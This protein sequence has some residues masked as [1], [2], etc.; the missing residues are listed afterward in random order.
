MPRLLK[1]SLA[2]FVLISILLSLAV[3]PQVFAAGSLAMLK[4]S[5][6]NLTGGLRVRKGFVAGQGLVMR[7]GCPLWVEF[8]EEGDVKRE[9]GG[10]DY[11]SAIVMAGDTYRFWKSAYDDV[12]SQYPVGEG[13]TPKAVVKNVKEYGHKENWPLKP[14]TYTVLVKTWPLSEGE[15]PILLEAPLDLNELEDLDKAYRCVLLSD[16]KVI[17][18]RSTVN[19]G[20]LTAFYTPKSGSTDFKESGGKTLGLDYL[21]GYNPDK[22]KLWGAFDCVPVKTTMSQYGTT[23][24]EDGFYVL[25]YWVW[26]CPC[27]W[28]DIA[29]S[30]I[31]WTELRYHN[32]NP[33]SQ[34]GCGLYYAG[35]NTSESCLGGITPH[36][37]FN[38][39]IDMAMLTGMARVKNPDNGEIPIVEA[40]SATENPTTYSYRSTEFV[41]PQP[42]GTPES[43]L[44]DVNLFDAF[45]F[46]ADGEEDIAEVKRYKHPDN[47]NSIVKQEIQIWFG[48]KTGD[49]GQIRKPDLTRL[50]DHTPDLDHQGLLKQIS[51]KDLEATDIFVYRLSNNQLVC[52]RRGIKRSEGEHGGYQDGGVDLAGQKLYFR[53]PMRG[54]ANN[55]QLSGGRYFFGNNY[56]DWKEAQYAYDMAEG[57]LLSVKADHLRVGEPVKVILINRVTGYMGSGTATVGA[58]IGDAL[59]GENIGDLGKNSS[60]NLLSF[61]CE[62]IVMEPPNIRVRAE[63]SWKSEGY[64]PEEK[65]SLVGFEGAGLTSD[66]HI[67]VTV[68]WLDRDG[69]PLPDDLPGFTGRLAKVVPEGKLQDVTIEGAKSNIS[70]FE[71][72]PGLHTEILYLPQTIDVAHYYIHINGEPISRNPDFK[73]LGVIE[74]ENG[75]DEESKKDLTGRPARYVPFQVPI[76]HEELTREAQL[77]RNDQLVNNP[78]N[79]ENLSKT[80]SPIHEWVY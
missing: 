68:E 47:S 4:E 65:E 76:F 30:N 62:P 31:I 29:Y 50:V 73:T 20:Y 61:S 12:M 13:E 75:K 63:R 54:P 7:N 3:E 37:N 6:L 48:S 67:R 60:T 71:I 5:M 53:T 72:K 46:N 19:I 64:N 49:D 14:T 8:D 24:D 56:H 43:Q 36:L 25:K 9:I 23:T 34:R 41:E 11:K 17:V 38:I 15:S 35:L 22:H 28:C 27:P 79:P 70:Q 39:A 58:G 78:E 45:D 32:F 69:S 77:Y 52:S 21:A 10:C 59:T 66:K 57:A 42:G 33:K 2:P 16:K 40:K 80:V 1:K 51:K 26:P 55:N 74:D 44:S 18:E